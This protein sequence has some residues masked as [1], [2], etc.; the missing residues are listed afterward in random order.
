MSKFAKLFQLSASSVDNRTAKIFV[1]RTG[2]SLTEGNSINFKIVSLEMAL[3]LKG[4]FTTRC[5]IASSQ[6][7]T[8][9]APKI[10]LLSKHSIR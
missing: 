9:I 1:K 8:G 5:D 2:Q 10:L 6:N 7:I 4:I 3:P